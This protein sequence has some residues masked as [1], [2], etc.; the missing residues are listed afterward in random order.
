M[1]NGLLPLYNHEEHTIPNTNIGLWYNKFF[2]EWKQS[3]EKGKINWSIK[4]N[5]K[6][7][8][9][10]N[11][12]NK[13][14]IG[15][16]ELLHESIKRYIQ[17]VEALGGKLLYFKNIS[18]FVVG[19]GNTHPIENGFTWHYNLG[20]PYIPGSSIKGLVRA[21][22]RSWD[23]N[24]ND[25]LLYNLLGAE[26]E[27]DSK[28]GEVIFFDALPLQPVRLEPDIMT[29][30]YSTYYKEGVA[31][32]DWEN[33]IPI[34]FLTVSPNQYFILGIATRKTENKESLFIIERWLSEAFNLSGIG[35]KTSVGYGLFEQKNEN[36]L[37]KDIRKFIGGD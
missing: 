21:W 24:D 15:N 22:A 13:G 18:S 33:P 10:Q 14:D 23:N 3:E 9:I 4:E 19:M 30:H 12:T 26:K 20:L 1:P 31:P 37:P 7:K 29:V 35:A 6:L 28:S 25:E 17:L 5:G 2:N 36:E 16:K 32:G 11:L 27:Q 34:P 8:W